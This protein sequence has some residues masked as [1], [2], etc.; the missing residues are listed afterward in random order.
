MGFLLINIS[1]SL[2]AMT[3]Q[4]VHVFES[5]RGL[6]FFCGQTIWKTPYLYPTEFR[7]VESSIN[8]SGHSGF[9]T[10]QP[11]SSCSYQCLARGVEPSEP[12]MCLV[13]W[14]P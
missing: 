6:W 14:P 7:Q 3:Q 9:V 4:T 8:G 5:V 12:P 10:P 13:V 1:Q 11:R 2:V